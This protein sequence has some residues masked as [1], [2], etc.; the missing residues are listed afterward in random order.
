MNH[1]PSKIINNSNYNN[2]NSNTLLFNLLMRMK[3][4]AILIRAQELVG[5]N[6]TKKYK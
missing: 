3:A 1:S 4:T 2:S 5:N 6:I